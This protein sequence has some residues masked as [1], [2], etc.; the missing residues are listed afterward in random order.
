MNNTKPLLELA[1]AE[2][3][4]ALQHLDHDAEVS[5]QHVC[6]A[7]KELKAVEYELWRAFVHSGVPYKTEVKT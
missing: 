7:G 5:Y 6:R 4:V 2:L 3:S 1:I